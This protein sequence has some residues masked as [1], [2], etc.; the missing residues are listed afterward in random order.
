MRP[1]SRSIINAAF[2]ACSTEGIPY[3]LELE[4][5]TAKGRQDRRPGDR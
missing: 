3:D 4:I 5:I 1:E 2:A